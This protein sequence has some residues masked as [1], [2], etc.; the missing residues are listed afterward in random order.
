LNRVTI[1]F[2]WQLVEMSLDEYPICPII[3]I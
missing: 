3:L 1:E 2:V